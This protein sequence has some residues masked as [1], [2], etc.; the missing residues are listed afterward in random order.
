MF[1]GKIYD[2][3]TWLSFAAVKYNENSYADYIGGFV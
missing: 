1:V 2:G 3:R